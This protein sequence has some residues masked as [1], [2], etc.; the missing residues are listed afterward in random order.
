MKEGKSTSIINSL[1]SAPQM[2]LMCMRCFCIYTRIRVRN[3]TN[4]I[5]LTDINHACAH[6]HAEWKMKCL[7]VFVYA[8]FTQK[9]F[10]HMLV[11]VYDSTHSTHTAYTVAACPLTSAA[12][13]I[14][15]RPCRDL[16]HSCS[17]WLRTFGRQSKTHTLGSWA[18]KVR[19]RRQLVSEYSWRRYGVIITPS[20]LAE[21]LKKKKFITFHH[22]YSLDT[23][24]PSWENWRRN[25]DR[26]LSSRSSY[27]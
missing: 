27:G 25:L 23:T 15:E 2:Q 6:A 4:V 22:I 3:G 18:R 10:T 14:E 21:N 7:Q 19:T 26:R 1:R 16:S 9:C 20:A 8:R 12:S 11:I 24:S 17:C 13:K 5:S